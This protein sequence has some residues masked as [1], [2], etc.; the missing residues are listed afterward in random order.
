MDRDE[1][2]VLDYYRSLTHGEKIAFARE[3]FAMF[4]DPETERKL[5]EKALFARLLNCGI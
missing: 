4:P 2:I 5:A 1:M 3:F